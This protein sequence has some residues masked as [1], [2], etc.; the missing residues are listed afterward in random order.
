M[1]LAER[2][3]LGK[4]IWH[5]TLDESRLGIKGRSWTL[6]MRER[7]GGQALVVGG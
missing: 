3:D 7:E 6:C 5:G 2:L 1:K 4:K